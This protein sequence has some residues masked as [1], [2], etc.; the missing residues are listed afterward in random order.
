MAKPGYQ[1]NPLRNRLS[2][3]LFLDLY[4][5]QCLSQADIAQR[6]EVS[7]A[8]VIRL[9][10]QYDIP[11]NP[12]VKVDRVGQSRS[13]ARHGSLTKYATTEEIAKLYVHDGLSP[14]EIAS[15]YGVTRKGVWKYLKSHG[16]PT[17]NQYDARRVA[18]ATGRVTN[19]P[20]I[21]DAFFSSWTPQ[22]AWVLGLLFTDGDMSI[23]PNG[24]Y[25]VGISSVDLD[26]LERIKEAME[27]EHKIQLRKQ[28]LGGS[29]YR[30]GWY[31]TKI[32]QD[33][34]RLGITPKKSLTIAYPDV[35]PDCERDFIRGLFD[36]DGSVFIEPRS[37]HSPLRVHYVSGSQ[38]FVVRLEDRLHTLGGL[39]KQTIYSRPTQ[40]SYYFKYGHEDSLKFFKLIYGANCNRIRLE[41]KYHRFIEG[42]RLSGMSEEEIGGIGVSP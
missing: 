24:A 8:Y 42:M 16:I 7:V 38:Q 21:N 14:A 10:K 5:R 2:R 36:G 27:S 11:L 1:E 18:R 9:R 26:L 17:R 34:L 28:T 33:L 35:P 23:G 32:S 12:N 41:R 3:D 20:P 19:E 6:F 13:G 22:M 30:L 4:H 37:P 25:M 15:R 40:T 29:I 31:R 39:R